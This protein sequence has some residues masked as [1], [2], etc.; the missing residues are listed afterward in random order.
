LIVVKQL[1]IMATTSAPSDNHA[2]V[3]GQWKVE[4]SK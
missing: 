4:R 2:S 1:T 3:I